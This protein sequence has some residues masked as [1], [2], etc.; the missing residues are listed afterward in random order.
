MG[1]CGKILIS[2]LHNLPMLF[3]LLIKYKFSEFLAALHKHEGPQLKA[4][5]RRF[6]QQRTQADLVGGMRC[7]F[8]MNPMLHR[9]IMRKSITSTYLHLRGNKSKLG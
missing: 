1:I 5:W 3:M 2:D 6:C 4:F 8:A 7:R 9:T